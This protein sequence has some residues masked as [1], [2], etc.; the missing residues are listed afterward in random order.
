MA[1]MLFPILK[2]SLLIQY[3]INNTSLT[4]AASDPQRLTDFQ[5]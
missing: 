5:R 3:K 4:S 2:F 1:E